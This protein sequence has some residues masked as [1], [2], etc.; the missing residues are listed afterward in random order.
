ML[1]T[2]EKEQDRLDM[3]HEIILQILEGR[4]FDAPI[5]KTPQKIL[6]VGTGTGIWAID[7]AD[8]FPMAEVSGTDLSPIQ[9]KWVPPN[10]KFEVDDAERRWTYKEGLFDFIHCRNL[11]GSINNW[12][13]LAAEIYRCTKPGGYAELAELGSKVLCDDGT[14]KDDNPFK[15]YSEVTIKAMEAM[16]RTWPTAN[17]LVQ[18]LKNAGFVD[19]TLTV[20][21]QPFGPWPKDKRLKHIGAMAM[22]M[23]ETGLEA[24]G[25]AAMTRILKMDPVEAMA[26]CKDAFKAIKNRHTHMY[27]EL[28]VVYGKKPE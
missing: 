3:H 26:I 14:M 24:Y 22:V 9:P 2:D 13:N 25:L 10:C 16:G 11:G 8:M 5:G 17:S 27:N 6:D 1:P 23:A 7:V 18:T 4:L 28:F 15:I 20:Y 12:S 19:V 21:K